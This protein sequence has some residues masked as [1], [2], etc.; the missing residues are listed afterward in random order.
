MM[1]V[2]GSLSPSRR[3]AVAREGP[4][5]TLMCGGFRLRASDGSQPQSRIEKTDGGRPAAMVSDGEK[6]AATSD[7][8]RL[9]ASDGSQP[10]SRMEKNDGER[11]AATVVDVERS[12]A[13]MADEHRLPTK[14]DERREP[15]TRPPP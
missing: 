11:P 13:S 8:F 4:K 10:Q 6:P 3:H 9:R 2:D 7:E 5:T 14:V 12:V 1:A 15:T